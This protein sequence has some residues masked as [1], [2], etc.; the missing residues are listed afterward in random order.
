MRVI[1]VAAFIA[2]GGHYSR[3]VLL[4]DEYFDTYGNVSWADEK[5]HLDN[6]AFELQHDPKLIGYIVVYAGRRACLGEAKYRALRAKKYLVRTR[7][8][9]ENRIR[10]MDGGYQEELRIVL[11]PLQPDAPE[12]TAS[13]TLKPDE[14]LVKNCK[15]KSIKRRKRG[16]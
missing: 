13:P 10:W 1:S 5:A 4:S 16:S 7:N 11:Q 8:I 9:Q 12:F 3:P 6:F 2:V 15:P 14:A